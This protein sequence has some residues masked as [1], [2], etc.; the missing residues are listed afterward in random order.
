MQISQ[1]NFDAAFAGLQFACKERDFDVCSKFSAA[2]K[3]HESVDEE[4]L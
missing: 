3:K 1:N 4:K 2:I